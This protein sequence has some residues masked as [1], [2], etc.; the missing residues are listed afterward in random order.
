MSCESKKIFSNFF[1]YINQLYCCKSYKIILLFLFFSQ[2]FYSQTADSLELL[3]GSGLGNF[4]ST[5]FVK[6]LSTHNLNTKFDISKSVGK[7][8]IN[9][10]ENFNSTFV[11]STEKS[12]RDEQFLAL[13]TKYRV[14]PEATFGIGLK[15]NIFSD[16]RRIEINQASANQIFLF[17][18]IIPYDNVYIA[19]FLGYL[20]NRQ[21]LNDDNGLIYGTEARLNGIKISDLI[22]SSDIKFRNEDITP[23]KNTLRH[24]NLLLNSEFTDDVSNFV[25]AGYSQNRKDFYFEADSITSREFNVSNNIQSRIET[26]YLLQDRLKYNN[27]FDLFSLDIAGIVNWRKIE[28]DTRYKSVQN[29]TASIFD[30]EINELKLDFE[31]MLE[32]SNQGILMDCFAYFIPNVMK[33]ILQKEFLQSQKIFTRTDCSLKEEKIIIQSEHHF[34]FLE[35]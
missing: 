13:Q 12:I 6:Q 23:R 22:V 2:N 7:F 5:R 19:P 1:I 10:I 18:N 20:N 21:V 4:L 14:I 17:S 16:S 8:D 11:K 31:S 32:L 3:S 25:N 33:K 24:F 30:T 26:N 34:P 9:I 15:S 28:R 27:F 35:I 29:A